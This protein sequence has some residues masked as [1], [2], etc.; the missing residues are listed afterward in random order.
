MLNRRKKIKR[1]KQEETVT[2]IVAKT[3]MV[4]MIRK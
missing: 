2:A 1:K 4:I 3:I